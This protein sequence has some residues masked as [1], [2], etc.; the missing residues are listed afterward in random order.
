MGFVR[1]KKKMLV[2]IKHMLVDV[3]LHGENDKRAENCEEFMP[4]RFFSDDDIIP[5][6]KKLPK[7]IQAWAEERN[8]KTS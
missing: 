4:E 1:D 2:K 3:F 8:K 6:P 5:I 7:F